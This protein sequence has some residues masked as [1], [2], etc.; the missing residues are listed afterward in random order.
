V[1]PGLLGADVVAAKPR[2][3]RA[4]GARFVVSQGGHRRGSAVPTFGGDQNCDPG[5]TSP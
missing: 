5:G 3:S 4:A 1:G 2:R